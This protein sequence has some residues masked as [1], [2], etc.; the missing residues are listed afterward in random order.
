M[1]AA[2]SRACLASSWIFCISETK[3]VDAGV[4]EGCLGLVP[5]EDVSVI[6]IVNLEGAFTGG[7]VYTV[8]VSEC[9]RGIAI[10][11]SRLEDG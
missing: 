8:I 7:E 11:P 10:Q 1:V 6:A 3:V 5:G 4:L 9:L 2:F